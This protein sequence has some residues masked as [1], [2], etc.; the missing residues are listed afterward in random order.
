MS[1]ARSDTHNA[2]VEVTEQNQ[3]GDVS[4]KSFRLF[5][6]GF[7]GLNTVNAPILMRK[8]SEFPFFPPPFR[9]P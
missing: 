7:R 8:L 4:V 9:R 2:T 5:N 6:L 3:R 1:L